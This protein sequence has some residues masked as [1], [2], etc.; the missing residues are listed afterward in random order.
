MAQE[1]FVA[2]YRVS[3]QRQGLSRLGKEAQQAA[4][5]DYLNGGHWRLLA[6]F[7]E[8]ESGG[9]DVGCQ[10]A[11]NAAGR[12]QGRPGAPPRCRFVG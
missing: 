10:G 12:L 5:R 7:V 6:E 2:Y 1:R 8:V 3:T 11:G 9:N 4:V